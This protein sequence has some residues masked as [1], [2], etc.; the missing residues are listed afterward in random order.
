V[1]LTQMNFPSVRKDGPAV[2]GPRHLKA[3]GHPL[4]SPNAKIRPE[5]TLLQIVHEFVDRALERG[6]LRL[7][8][9]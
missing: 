9:A 5:L 1:G 4:D 2:S 8:Q 3:A 7:R 6:S